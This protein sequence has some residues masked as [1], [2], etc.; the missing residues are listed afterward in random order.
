MKQA[1]DQMKKNGNDN[2]GNKILKGLMDPV[3]MLSEAMKNQKENNNA[4][5]GIYSSAPGNVGNG[6]NWKVRLKGR[7]GLRKKHH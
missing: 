3:K 5:N 6:D 7:S 4:T 2:D 1:H